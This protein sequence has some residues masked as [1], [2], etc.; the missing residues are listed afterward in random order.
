MHVKITH[1]PK[2]RTILR[3]LTMNSTQQL[4]AKGYRMALLWT[5][6][7]LLRSNGRAKEAF[8][9]EPIVAGDKEPSK[10]SVLEYAFLLA[11]ACTAVM[12][13]IMG[14]ASLSGASISPWVGAALHDLECA[15]GASCQPLSV[16]AIP[17]NA[18]TSDEWIT[19]LNGNDDLSALSRMRR[20]I[21]NA[22]GSLFLMDSS[23]AA[24]V[25]KALAIAETRF[26]RAA[27]EKTDAAIA[28]Q[29]VRQLAK[30]LDVHAASSA[31]LAE[32]ANPGADP[33][34]FSKARL[35]TLSGIAVE[36]A[37]TQARQWATPARMWRLAPVSDVKAWAA[38]TTVKAA[39][40]E[41]GAVAVVASFFTLFL[42]AFICWD[43]CDEVAGWLDAHRPGLEKAQ[44]I[45][46]IEMAARRGQPGR[47]QGRL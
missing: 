29:F 32:E 40:G 38:E 47:E 24:D 7:R 20:D 21:H 13:I 9:Q 46:A 5:A 42:I 1:A 8:K 18:L 28:A 27:S 14:L 3:K 36:I 39:F 4:D 17:V 22:S 10:T 43:L 25:V 2:T 23:I 19:V 15:H 26:K 44:E 6:L 35:A 33:S 45:F 30:G 12:I 41:L 37:P 34:P 31:A 16:V 11:A